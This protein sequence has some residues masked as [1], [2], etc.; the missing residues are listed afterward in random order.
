M[1]TG[2]IIIKR[3]LQKIGASSAVS[4]PEPESIQTALEALNSMIAMW[5]AQGIDIDAVALSVA[6]DELGEKPASTNAVIYNLAIFVS[7]DF[8]NGKVIVSQELRMLAA[9]ELGSVKALYQTFTIPKKVVSSTLPKGQGNRVWQ[10]DDAFF[11][12]GS[13]LGN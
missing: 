3:A 4:E 11:A 6:G 9:V 12:E 7:P 5:A 10:F 2:T 13:E 8:D 1:T